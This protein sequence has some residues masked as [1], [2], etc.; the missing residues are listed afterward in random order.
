MGG[1]V[2]G[3]AQLG[4]M[5]CIVRAGTGVAVRS[6]DVAMFVGCCLFVSANGPNRN[7]KT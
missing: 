7:L 2:V 1:K 5:D 3:A 4:S 6:R